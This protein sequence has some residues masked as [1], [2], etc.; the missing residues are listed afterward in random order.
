M[1]NHVLFDHNPSCTKIATGHLR[2]MIY[3]SVKNE[4]SVQSVTGREDVRQVL[5]ELRE[6]SLRLHKVLM[7][8]ERTTY[9]Q[10]FGKIASPYQFLQ[11]LT[12]DA[13]F[14]WLRPLTRLI[15]AMDERLEAKERLTMAGVKA[16]ADQA[17]ALLVATA[18]ND[19]FA[20]HY[21]EALQRD[22]DVV[23]AHAEAARCLRTATTWQGHQ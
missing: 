13:W 9:E 8:S 1:A 23:F 11:L 6:A 4:I 17:R 16:L 10:T 2:Y 7:D 5:T 14:A 20:G 22:P 12:T 19:G 21:D 15:A 3:C 18:G